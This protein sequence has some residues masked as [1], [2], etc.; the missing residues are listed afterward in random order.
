MKRLQRYGHGLT[1]MSWQDTPSWTEDQYSAFQKVMDE[2][3]QFDNTAGFLVGNEVLTT[4]S[5]ALLSASEYILT[6]LLQETT[7]L[8]HPMSRLLL[9]T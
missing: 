4:G 3:Q 9:V 8:L 6:D 2:F 7:P 5:S 1:D